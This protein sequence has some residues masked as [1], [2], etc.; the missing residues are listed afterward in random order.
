MPTFIE[1]CAGAGGLSSGFIQAGWTPILLNDINKDCCQTLQLNHPNTHIECCHMD[2]IDLKKIK[3]KPDIVMGGIPCQSFS[4]AGLRKGLDDERGQLIYQFINIVKTLGPSMF[5]I[6]NVK[7]MFTHNGG[8]TFKK[9]LSVLGELQ[10]YTIHYKIL[11]SLDYGV[12][13]KRERLFIVGTQSKYNHFVF[14]RQLQCEKKVLRDVLVGVP[15]SP[16]A[17][18][19]EDKKRLFQQIPQGGCWVNLPQDTQLAYLGKSY[20]SAGGKRGILRRLSMDEP[21]LTL[22]CTPTQKQTERCHPTED[23]P[24]SIREYARIQTFP[25]DYVFY[26]GMASQ[27]RQIGNAV[28]VLLAKHVALSLLN[29]L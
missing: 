19:T 9:V 26:G 25:D 11:N 24:L 6:E 3:E 2:E 29:V 23:R 22:L 10:Q 17:K 7:G 5:M 12:P 18:Y 14:P 15:G 21:C 28:P 1:V 4:H 16:C 20:D 27:Y 8:N 13:Q